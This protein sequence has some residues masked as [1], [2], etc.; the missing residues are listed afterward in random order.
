MTHG[1]DRQPMPHGLQGGNI[2]PGRLSPTHTLQT[3][4][5]KAPNPNGR[6]GD[7]QSNIGYEEKLFK[8]ADIR[9]GGQ[10]NSYYDDQDARN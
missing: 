2:A 5:S 6:N 1:A 8:A 10:V 4:T 3:A 9:P 7:T